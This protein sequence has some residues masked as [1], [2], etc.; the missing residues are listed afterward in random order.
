MVWQRNGSTT[1]TG[2]ASSITLT[3][4]A[5]KIFNQFLYH[6]ITPGAT[7]KEA[8]RF[9]VNSNAVY[10]WRAGGTNPDRTDTS[11]TEF[12]IIED[13]GNEDVFTVFYVMSISG[14][15]KLL[16]YFSIRR[17]TAGA[18]TAPARQESVAKFVPSPDADITSME[19]L[20]IAGGNDIG[21]DSNLSA[22]GTD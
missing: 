12:E 11:D 22:L 20:D 6:G 18:G 16:I 8:G 10:A 19:I 5:P 2:N 15:E 1:L 7:Q 3:L 4:D 13:N 9:N 17:S 21:I 14:E